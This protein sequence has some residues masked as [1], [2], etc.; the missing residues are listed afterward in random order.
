MTV[1]EEVQTWGDMYQRGVDLWVGLYANLPMVTDFDSALTYLIHIDMSVYA[2]IHLIILNA[3]NGHFPLSW[4]DC[5]EA[6]F[7]ARNT[8][9]RQLLEHGI[10]TRI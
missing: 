7:R 9:I 4:K 6:S 3:S 2:C 10:P 5:L 1:I 8:T